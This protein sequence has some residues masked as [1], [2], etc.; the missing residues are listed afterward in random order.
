MLKN[1]L[2]KELFE[3]ISQAN[4]KNIYELR[5]RVGN[6]ILA[7]YLNE[8]K[9]LTVSGLSNSYKDAIICTKQ[10]IDTI[11]F[12]ATNQS[13]YSFSEQI[14][15]GFITLKGG[16]RIGIAGEAVIDSGKVNTI[17]NFSSLNIRIPHEVEGCSLVAFPYL[18]KDDTLLNTLIISPPGAGKTTFLRDLA[19]QI[20]KRLPHLNVLILD[21][22]Y[23]IASSVNGK[24]ELAVGQADIL[25]GTTKQFGFEVGI[26]SMSPQIIFTDELATKEDIKAIMYAKGCGVK[27]IASAHS[28]SALDLKNKSYFKYFLKEKVFER[29]V[30]L[31]KRKV[32]G[33]LEGIFDSQLKKLV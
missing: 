17:K 26:R 7:N 10:M 4:I 13:L 5:L 21:E 3:T 33:T 14:K 27:V 16:I 6:A 19:L 20:H 8:L 31:S 30:V 18:L 28:Y 9:F 15:Q 11:I 32:V 23:E 25:S 22:R 2:P 1:I 29:F 12:K 24:T